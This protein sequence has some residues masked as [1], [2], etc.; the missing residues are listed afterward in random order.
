[1][2]NIFYLFLILTFIGIFLV[3]D[4]CFK[5]LFVMATLRFLQSKKWRG[6]GALVFFECQ[7]LYLIF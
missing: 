7:E 6:L 2:E 3:S 4:Y 1:M 5:T